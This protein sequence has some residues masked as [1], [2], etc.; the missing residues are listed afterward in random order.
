MADAQ[1]PVE[2]MICVKCSMG[3]PVPEG[4]A[5]SGAQL[6]AAVIA[7]DL[8]EG[9]KVTPVECFSNCDHGCSVTFRG[10]PDRWTYIYGDMDPDEHVPQILDGIRADAGTPDGLVPW[11]ERPEVFR[12]QSIA[13]IPPQE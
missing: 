3:R 10:G 5:T 2:L 11:R 7:R 8:P 12:K 1:A 6:H 13:R 9:V 4:E